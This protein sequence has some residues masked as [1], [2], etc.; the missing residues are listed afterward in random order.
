M[1]SDSRGSS[2][3]VEPLATSSLADGEHTWADTDPTSG[4]PG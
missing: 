4:I 3:L 1:S 2:S